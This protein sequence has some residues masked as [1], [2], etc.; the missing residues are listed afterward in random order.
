MDKRAPE[1]KL[2]LSPALICYLYMA[3][4]KL[5]VAWISASV[6]CK[7]D[8]V[9]DIVTP[10]NMYIHVEDVADAIQQYLMERC[11]RSFDF[12]LRVRNKRT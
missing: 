11:K 2:Y 4:E 10:S 1:T 7:C 6:K 12:C 3:N 5:R 9:Y 8:H